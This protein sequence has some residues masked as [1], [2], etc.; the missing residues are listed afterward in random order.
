MF[1]LSSKTGRIINVGSVNG[2]CAYPGFSVYCA[3]KYAIEG[4]TDAIRYELS[5]LGITTV[6]I[7]PG[8]FARLT[9]IMCHHELHMKQ[10]WQQMSQENKCL[11]QEYFKDYEHHVSK[12]YGYTSPASY[13][14]S[15]IFAHFKSAV[16]AR[17]PKYSYTISPMSQRMFFK[18]LTILPP[19]FKDKLIHF[20]SV[21]V[22]NFDAQKYF[23]Q[24]K[25]LQGKEQEET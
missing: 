13:E 8:D 12:N 2:T 6:L 20:I 11:Y 4:F 18:L 21:Q 19:S 16:L 23:T 5:K 9:R 25:V 14:D 3:T 22:F 17:D 7:R 15:D 1:F 24:K 10:M